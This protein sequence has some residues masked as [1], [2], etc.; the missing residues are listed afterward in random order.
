MA[1]LHLIG[2]VSSAKNFEQ[3]RLFC[4][5]SFSTDSGWK[6]INGNGEGQTQ[7]CADPFSKEPVWD[8]PIDIHFAT[9]TLQGSPKVLLQV[10]CRDEFNRIIFVS[11]GISSIPLRPGLHSIE[12][13]TW[14]PIG[15]WQDKLKDKFLGTTLQLKSPDVLAPLN[16]KASTTVS[17]LSSST[18][19]QRSIN[20]E[21]TPSKKKKSKAKKSRQ[22]EVIE[23]LCSC[24]LTA[25]VC[26]INCC[27][28]PDC[29]EAQQKVFSNCL[30]FDTDKENDDWYCHRR[31]F[32]RHNETRFIL[33]KVVDSLFCIAS[34]NLPP[35]YPITSKVHI[36]DERGLKKAIDDNPSSQFKWKIDPDRL[37]SVSYQDFNL[38]NTYTHGDVIIKI[39]RDSLLQFE[40]PQT[41][42]GKACDFIKTVK[43]LEDWKSSCHQTKLSSKN[44]FLFPSNFNNITV[45][46]S[47]SKF[48]SQ[49]LL[50]DC[51]KSVCLSVNMSICSESWTKCQNNKTVRSLCGENSCYN[52]VKKVRYIIYHN[53]SEGLKNIEV[54]LQLTNVSSTFKQ[55]FEVNYKW[56]GLNQSKVFE[57]SG[58]PGYS[59]GKYIFVGDEVVNKTSDTEIRS[60][61]LNT[62]HPYLTL[63]ST[64]KSGVCKKI[65]RYPI[66]FLE[67]TKLKCSISIETTN[68]STSDCIKL[69]NRTYEMLMGAQNFAD[70]NFDK[71][72]SRSGNVS[73]NHTDF[74]VRIYGKI[75]QNVISSKIVENEIHCSGL[76]TSVVFNIVHSRITKPG[77][78]KNHMIVGVGI[79]F[80]QSTDLKWPKCTGKNC[81]DVLQVNIVSFVSFHDVSKPVRYHIA[82]GPNLDISLPY[83]FFYP[84]I[85]HHSKS[86]G[87]ISYQHN[88][89]GISMIV[90][91]LFMIYKCM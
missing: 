12:C 81:R 28:D 37:K 26:D 71:Y 25:G 31:P 88:V 61:L 72:V 41:G 30:D 90:C 39:G 49:Y 79:T 7:E 46:A 73:N 3:P 67:D 89:F 51:P 27:C 47:P 33:E 65:D 32:F 10:F 24:D 34:D 59:P 55:E 77:V 23:K 86:V 44:N 60:V 1:E 52:V 22:D 13:H 43:F 15:N 53:G 42:F 56:S 64:D 4:K 57:R 29:T 54:Y 17:P 20:K 19:T 91:I 76:V 82:G 66:R 6:I 63:P 69:H 87:S 62:S 40:L 80:S 18:T 68:F 35:T 70:I 83:D 36:E 5:W 78:K 16:P 9:Q 50:Q 2:T 48:N 11:Y 38:S 58:N 8:H 85:S 84:F 45:L 21:V 74:W 14:K 75:P